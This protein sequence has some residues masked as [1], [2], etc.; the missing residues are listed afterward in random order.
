M[1]RN[2]QPYLDAEQTAK[3]DVTVADTADTDPITGVAL[4]TGSSRLA[5]DMRSV[6]QLLDWGQ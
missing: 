6:V 5:V 2:D 4:V 3:P 1:S